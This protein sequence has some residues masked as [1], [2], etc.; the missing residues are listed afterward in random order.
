MRIIAGTLRGRV[1]N[2]PQKDGLR[3]TTDKVREAVFS[4][5]D[6]LAA[7]SGVAVL[8]LYAGTGSLAFEALSRG[9]E[10]A[11]L[12][13]SNEEIASWLTAAAQ[14]LKLDGACEVVCSEVE[15]AVRG[16]EPSLPEGGPYGLV[17]ID[18]PYATH[19][20]V[21]LAQAL[22]EAKL[23]QPGSV[24]VVESATRDNIGTASDGALELIKEKVYGDTRVS[25]FQVR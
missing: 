25:F 8:D 5:L 9:A 14:K 13:E 21:P 2:P 15:R 10:R 20:G 16:G 4:V 17:F 12:V 3:P 24:I 23:V 7:V 1:L 18:P 19:P 11:L 6:G 22:V